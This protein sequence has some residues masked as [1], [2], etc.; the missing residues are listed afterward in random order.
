MRLLWETGRRPTGVRT[1][2]EPMCERARHVRAFTSALVDDGV[3]SSARSNDT[4]VSVL[5]NGV[6]SRRRFGRW[7]VSTT[8]E[9]QR[10]PTVCET[11]GATVR[12][13]GLTQGE[14]DAV[15]SVDDSAALSLETMSCTAPL[16]L[17]VDLVY[18]RRCF[19]GKDE[20]EKFSKNTCI[21][22]ILM[23]I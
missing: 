7:A 5:E 6:A 23:Y 11:I 22:D 2:D 1:Q 3:G 20:Q 9:G 13:S 8:V 15:S 18:E 12:N 17:T 4:V 16:I 10:G 21:V 14:R 19:P